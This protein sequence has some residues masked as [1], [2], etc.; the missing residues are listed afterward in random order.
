MPRVSVI[1]LSH[2]HP[3][4]LSR[5]IASALSQDYSDFE[6]I[7]VDDSSSDEPLRVVNSFVD[8]RIKYIRLEPGITPSA[9]DNVGINSA[10]G[11]YIAFLDDDDEWLPTKLSKQVMAFGRSG[12]SVGLIYTGINYIDEVK[13]SRKI[14]LP[15]WRGW[16]FD[17]LL[18]GCFIWAQSSVMIR[19][20]VLAEVNGFD[21]RLPCIHD[22]DLYLRV[23]KNCEFDYV[24]EVLV[25]YY[26]N[27]GGLTRN[28]KKRLQGQ[29]IVYGKIGNQIKSKKVWSN[30]YFHRGVW[31]FMLGD[32]LEGRRCLVESLRYNWKNLRALP[33]IV[34]SIM[35][36]ATF[37]KSYSIFES[38]PLA[39]Y[40]ANISGYRSA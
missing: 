12:S 38:T 21:G 31:L 15:A 36:A 35:G 23:A 5:S 17:R 11:D 27:Y 1:T 13:G 2:N 6:L 22:W 30:Y 34:L 9:A 37:N 7:V 18:M 32:H 40:L 33:L 19:K 39:T 3:F 24:P 28:L 10:H 16:V 4:L 20:D 29:S 26:C 14:I 25:N 8:P